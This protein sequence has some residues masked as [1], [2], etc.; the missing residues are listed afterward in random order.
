MPPCRLGDLLARNDYAAAISH[1]RAAASIGADAADAPEAL[2]FGNHDA[3]ACGDSM[4]A[5]ALTFLGDAAEARAGS[6]RALPPRPSSC[7]IRS[8]A[9]WRC[10]S[11]RCCISCSTSP[12]AARELAEAAQAQA[13]EQGFELFRAWSDATAGWAMAATGDGAAGVERLR[14]GLATARKTGTAQLLPYLRVLLADGC[15]R[16]RQGTPPGPRSR[17]ACRRWVAPAAA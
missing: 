1:A 12:S 9:R 8:A 14:Q 16:A 3:L 13:V 6:A 15:L 10:T 11:R 4:A 5:V 7:S 2:R 17:A